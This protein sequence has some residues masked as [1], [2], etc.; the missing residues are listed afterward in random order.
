MYAHPAEASAG[1]FKKKKCNG[2]II[3]FINAA[4]GQIIIIIIFIGYNVVY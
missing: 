3:V 2:P 4:I 1:L